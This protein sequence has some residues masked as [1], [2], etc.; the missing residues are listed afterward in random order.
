MS[1]RV[2]ELLAH[3]VA[4]LGGAERTGQV[5][6]AR[7]VH[8]AMES[9][10]HLAVQAGTGTGKSLAYLV[11]AIVR[12][13][14]DDQAV[15][16]S[17]AT[18]A[19][20]RQLVERDLPRLADALEPHLDRRPTFSILKGRNNYLCRNKVA[21]VPLD[22]DDGIGDTGALIDS[23]TLSKTA[24]QVLMLR[25]WANDTEDGDRD[26]LDRGVS[27]MAW[28]QV[29]VTSRECVGASKCPMGDT[30]F[31]EAAKARAADVDVVVTN[32]ALLAI[33]ALSDGLILP[34]HECVV[35]DEAHE[36]DAR[37]TSVATD[38]LTSTGVTLT[39]KRA[40][41]A[42]AVEEAGDLEDAAGMLQ[43]ALVSLGD[44]G[45]GRW[46]EIPPDVGVPL[47]A[48]RDAL[49][50]AQT[51][52]ATSQEGDA[53]ERQTV[54]AALENMHDAA[55]RI[56]A[57]DDADVVWLTDR[58]ALCVAPLTVSDLLRDRLFGENTVVL[59]SATL[60]LGGKFDAMAA[61]WGLPRGEWDGMDVGTPFDPAKSGILYVA[62]HLP[63]PGRDGTDPKVMDELASLITAAG[64]RTLGLF[65]SRRGAEAA[66]EEMRRRLPFEVLCQGDDAIGNL[67]EQFTASENSCLFGTLSLW[68]GV[69]VPGP[70][71][72]LV[73]IDRIPFPRPDD[74][75]LSARSDAANRAGRSGFMEVS[76]THAALLMAQGA[77]R[78][79]RSVDDRGVVA[80]L[81]PRLATQR[82]GSWIAASM[83][84]FW[85]TTDG[86]VARSALERLVAQRYGG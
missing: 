44:D 72:S 85:R 2:E 74:P 41:N 51:A 54:R 13:M 19:L 6:M 14:E 71:L 81:D 47:T 27:D 23:S 68:Q 15:I 57:L 79:L 18:I 66:A 58:R 84:P 8:G 29:S 10:R 31:A 33:D 80:V 39:A 64:G 65:S 28:R 63:K 1:D 24:A 67:V 32:H 3:A 48:L 34:Q 45:V 12:A 78:L 69:D 56:L 9:G 42:G 26:S 46:E 53:T 38:E 73:V 5:A 60:A 82:Y 11:P 50:R 30:C 36:L 49:W 86:A 20:Q 25:E 17:T 52:L 61:A 22:P 43:E 75:L 62:R 77:G 21:E 83:P 40:K 59:T 4:A 7:A 55:V 35:V 37:I 76:A 70:S 16:V